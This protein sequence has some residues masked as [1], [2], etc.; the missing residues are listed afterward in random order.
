VTRK[1]SPTE[2]QLTTE[3]PGDCL[4]FTRPPH[5]A[6]SVT[7]KALFPPSAPRSSQTWGYFFGG[8]S[9]GVFLWG[10]FFGGISF[11]VSLFRLFFSHSR[12]SCA[13]RCP[14]PASPEALPGPR[15]LVPSRRPIAE[16]R[17]YG[18]LEWPVHEDPER[19]GAFPAISRPGWRRGPSRPGSGASLSSSLPL[20]R[21]TP[22][23][24]DRPAF[25][26]GHQA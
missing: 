14:L 26:H 21:S 10:Y 25:Q 17:W 7:Y 23:E 9:L 18:P 6:R 15:P 12:A 16:H 19:P 8:I 11:E 3:G 22:R 13:A 2:L 4:Q 24:V 1:R 5:A 20:Q